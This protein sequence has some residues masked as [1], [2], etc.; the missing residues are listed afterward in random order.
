[1]SDRGGIYGWR[2]LYFYRGD[3]GRAAFSAVLGALV[4]C[5]WYMP[6]Q[7]Q[8]RHLAKSQRARPNL[9]SLGDGTGIDGWLLL[10]DRFDA[11]K[12]TPYHI[13]TAGCN[14]ANLA[15]IM[16]IMFIMANQKTWLLIRTSD[17]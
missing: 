6:F 9:F 12:R 7:L 10:S 1:L 13:M 8:N 2:I 4:H 11:A 15:F 16:F 14:A 17:L 3:T 5:H